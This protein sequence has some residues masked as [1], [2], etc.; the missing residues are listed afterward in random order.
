MVVSIWHIIHDG[1]ISGNVNKQK[2]FFVWITR[3]TIKISSGLAGM[4]SSNNNR[5]GYKQQQTT[6]EE[7]N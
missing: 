7:T 3:A 4:Y 5:G 2:L 1:L 6:V